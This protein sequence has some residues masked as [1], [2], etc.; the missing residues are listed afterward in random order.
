MGTFKF[1]I[2]SIECIGVGNNQKYGNG[3]EPNNGEQLK[4]NAIANKEEVGD[5]DCV[6]LTDVSYL[7]EHNADNRQSEYFQGTSVTKDVF[8]NMLKK[9]SKRGSKFLFMCHG[10]N[11]PP[12]SFNRLNNTNDANEPEEKKEEEEDAGVL[13]CGGDPAPGSM[14]DF[15]TVKKKMGDGVEVIPIIW[16]A[17]QKAGLDIVGRYMGD[18]DIAKQAGKAFSEMMDI[19]KS[20]DINTSL[21]CH[22]MGNMVLLQFIKDQMAAVAA[23]ED[24]DKKQELLNLKLFEHV[25]MAAPDIWD[26]MFNQSTDNSDFDG[27]QVFLAQWSK[28][29]H[30]VWNK[31]DTILN[32]ASTIGNGFRRRL[33]S[34]GFQLHLGKTHPDVIRSTILYDKEIVNPKSG[35]GYYVE[36]EAT[37]YMKLHMLG[38]ALTLQAEDASFVNSFL[39][40]NSDMVGFTGN[41]CLN[42]FLSVSTNNYIQWTFRLDNISTQFATFEGLKIRYSLNDGKPNKNNRPLRLTVNGVSMGNVSFWAGGSWHNYKYTN[43]VTPLGTETSAKL[44]KGENTIILNDTGYRSAMIDHLIIETI[45]EIPDEDIVPTE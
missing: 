6:F 14:Y 40:D 3:R 5:T 9:Y 21:M 42:P 43:P 1:L 23:M 26:I 30:C 18:R 41:N 27:T 24:E 39:N 12:Q 17:M 20:E 34:I 33:G 15:H 38:H 22:S 4:F 45:T 36:D 7:Q 11:D 31:G 10:F 16:P 8:L 35:H 32:W 2:T 28:N 44:Q 25:F 37:K 13:G 29:L 19:A